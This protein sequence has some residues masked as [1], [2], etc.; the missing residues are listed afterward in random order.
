VHHSSSKEGLLR[1]VGT[2]VALDEKGHNPA[3]GNGLIRMG[4]DGLPSTLIWAFIDDFKIHAPTMPKLVATL[5]AF[6]DLALWL[7]LICQWVKT[8]H[9]CKSKSRSI[10]V[11]FTT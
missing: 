4:K 10:V 3:L 8:N 1:T 2:P 5:N 7:G 9:P 6:M 11:S